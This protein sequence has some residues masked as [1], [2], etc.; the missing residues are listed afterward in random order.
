[1]NLAASLTLI[2]VSYNSA[3]II[4]EHL[5]CSQLIPAHQRPRHIVVDN[6]SKDGTVPLIQK[7]FSAVDI[8]ANQDNRGFG[9]ACNQGI[10]ASETPYVLILN[11]DTR[12]D[13]KSLE[14]LLTELIANPNAA[15]AGPDVAEG[16]TREGVESVDWV[17]GAAILMDK[18]KIKPLGFFDEDIF[19]YA[20][21]TELYVRVKKSGQDII[22]VFDSKM[23]HIGGASSEENAETLYFLSWHRGRSHRIAATKHPDHFMGL[24]AYLRKQ[25]RTYWI[26]RFKGNRAR[27][28]TARGKIDGAL[29]ETPQPK[30]LISF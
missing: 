25:R 28:V 11:P 4:E 10:Q 7:Q 17:I 5:S 1:M 22:Q 6:E 29:A 16:S 2:S 27:M 15:I 8:I 20:E 23:P 26:N 24:E 30:K 21:E 12:F 3:H 13:Q 9:T 14:I 19:L 18:E